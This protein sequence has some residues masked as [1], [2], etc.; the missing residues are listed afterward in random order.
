[1]TTEALEWHA[2]ELVA[3]SLG[4]LIEPLRKVIPQYDPD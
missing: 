4:A 3:P 1:M 2:V